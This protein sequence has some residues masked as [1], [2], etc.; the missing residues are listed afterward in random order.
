MIGL[1]EGNK[2]IPLTPTL[3]LGGEREIKDGEQMWPLTPTLSLGGRGGLGM[4]VGTGN[5]E[6]ELPG[7]STGDPFFSPLFNGTRGILSFPLSPWG[8]GRG[9]GEAW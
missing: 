6:S 9:E 5:G 7:S 1:V 2:R 3:S 4:A 8:E